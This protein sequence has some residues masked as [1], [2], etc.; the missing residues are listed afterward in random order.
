MSER[1]PYYYRS[2][3]TMARRISF[4]EYLFVLVMI[5]YAGRSIRYVT[6]LS[7]T[8]NPVWF[9]I[10]LLLSGLLALKWRIGFNKQFYLLIFI[11]LIYFAA[12]SIKYHEVRPTFFLNYVL[13]FFI[14][15]TTV[16]SLKVNFFILYENLIFYLAAI[17]I[18]LWVV[19]TALG[20]DTLYNYFG[21]IPGVAQFSYV[22]GQG[23]SGVLYSVQPSSM[24]IQFDFMPP[25]NCG[26]AWEPGGFAVYLCIALF[27][28]LYLLKVNKKNTIHFWVIL[29]A[30][31]STQSTTGY[32]IFIVILLGHYL[33]KRLSIVLLLLPAIITVIMLLS[34]LPFMSE[35]IVNLVNEAQEVD[36]MV[37]GSIG[38]ETPIGPQRFASF[39]IAF[40]DFCDNPILGIGGKDEERWTSKVGANV[41]TIT[42]LGNLLAYFG[43]VGFLFFTIVTWNTSV[44]FSDCFNY[45]GKWLFFAVMFLISISYGIILYPLVMSLWMYSLFEKGCSHEIRAEDL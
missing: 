20:G 5:I 14:V 23:Y 11:Y 31:V 19:Q 17:A 15:Y 30:L 41:S 1:P 44:R 43:L 37:E 8:E 40:R 36:I 13:L 35:K 28:N 26:F 18:L 4:Y 33:N 24:S 21:K 6:S 34:S 32:I 27:I 9:S 42:G 45:K 12:I 29:V 3:W 7:I 22:T 25:R 16:K 2:P 38:R 10:P 39:L